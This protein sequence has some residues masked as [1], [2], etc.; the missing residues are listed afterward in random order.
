MSRR[1]TVVVIGVIMLVLILTGVLVER[2]VYRPTTVSQS[3]PPRLFDYVVVILME[4]KSLNQ[5]LGNSCIGNCSYIDQ[6]ADTFGIAVNYSGVAHR[7]LPNYLTLTSGGNYS[8]SPFTTDCGPQI[9]NCTVSSRN[10]VDGIEASHRTWRAYIEDYSGGCRGTSSDHIPGPD[11]FLFYRDV[12]YNA[13]R[14]ANIV[15]ANPAAQG[16]LGIPTRLLSDLNQVDGTPNFMWL[17]PNL[18]D[19]GHNAC[20]STSLNGSC[21]F[22]ARCVSQG[23]EYLSLLVPQILES[24][25]FQTKNSA[26]FIT[27]DEGSGASCPII[28]QTYPTCIDRVPAIFAGPHVKE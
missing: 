4:N 28:G 1:S 20:N 24:H 9:G 26:L 19:S 8:Y 11:P 13:T 18:C 22:M 10:I 2:F 7:S 23:N 14:C 17:T 21:H 3:S 12:Y 6:L 15:E 25:T 27:W 5:T 16:Y